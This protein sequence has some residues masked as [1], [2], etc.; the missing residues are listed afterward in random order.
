[1][2]AAPATVLVL[3]AFA[4]LPS[5][6]DPIVTDRPDFTESAIVVP[7]GSTQIEMG[8][9]R[10]WV[11]GSRLNVGPE[12]LVRHGFQPNWEL[13][14]GAP[15]HFNLR[16]DGMSSSGWG[17]AYLGVKRQFGPCASGW[18]A[19]A[20]LFSF[21]PTGEDIFGADEA[22]PGFNLL[23]SKPLSDRQSLSAMLA[24]QWL[25]DDKGRPQL[26]G[27][28]SLGHGI[29]D[30][31]AAF[32]EYA[33]FFRRDERPDHVAHAGFTYQP[34]PTQQWDVHFG[35]SLNG[36]PRSTFVGVGFSA[37]FDPSR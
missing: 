37:R 5:P 15:N 13:R 33:G 29:T 21:L 25:A 30:K 19:A 11:N 2:L 4:A 1:M 20:I 8:V 34:S 23:A 28:L 12:L 10:E 7:L 32:L 31:L 18:D 27:T 24:T 26:T 17:D 22:E 35:R 14:V 9:T 16:A 3:S 6:R 36:S